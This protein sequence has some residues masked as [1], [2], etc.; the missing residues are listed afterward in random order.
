MVRELLPHRAPYRAWSNFEFRDTQGRWHEVDLLVIGER[1]LHLVEL[2]H[3]RGRIGGNGYR[4]TRNGRT[5]DSP[6]LLARR[7]AQRLASVIESKLK[8]LDWHGRA[9]WIQQSVFLP[10]HVSDQHNWKSTTMLSAEGGAGKG[11]G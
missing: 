4:W 9:P 1:R 11:T 5:E 3:Y 8:Q 2:K 7:K 10:T 6:V